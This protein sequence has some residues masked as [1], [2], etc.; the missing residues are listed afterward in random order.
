MWI[1]NT[2]ILVNRTE[3]SCDC[4]RLEVVGNHFPPG[5]APLSINML[6]TVSLKF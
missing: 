5:K 3:V 2:T 6:K 4:Y 1:A